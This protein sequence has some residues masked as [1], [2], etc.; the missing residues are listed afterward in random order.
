MLQCPPL[1]PGAYLMPENCQTPAP[2]P[3]DGPWKTWAP[4]LVGLGGMLLIYGM[5][6]HQGGSDKLVTQVQEQTIQVAKLAEQVAALCSQ[7]SK[8]ESKDR[9]QDVEIGQLRET[10]ARMLQ[11][12]GMSP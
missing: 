10:Q 8:K 7:V 5:T 1:A 2:P 11:R 12:L 9:E 6:A 4:S 3:Q